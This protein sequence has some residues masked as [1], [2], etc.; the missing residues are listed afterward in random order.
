MAFKGK[1]DEASD[2]V[3]EIICEISTGSGARMALLSTGMLCVS[4][5][6]FQVMTASLPKV[7]SFYALG[8]CYKLEEPVGVRE[9]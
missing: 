2:L 5:R 9:T 6:R 3:E 4:G 8:R 7:G 1:P